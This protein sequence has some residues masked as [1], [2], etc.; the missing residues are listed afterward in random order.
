MNEVES[1]L[2]V[3]L[4][5]YAHMDWGALVQVVDAI[6]GITVTLDEDIADDWTNT[7]IRAGEPATLDGEAAL[8]LARARHGTTYGDF[9]RGAS[10]QKII[11]A[12]K[13]RI[14]EKG[15][16]VAETVSLLNALGDNLR[17]NFS[18]GEIK[19]SAK[20]LQDFPENGIRQVPLL[21][22]ASGDYMTT[23]DI[24]GIS[25]VVPSAGV[26][27]Y[28]Y[29]QKYVAKMFSSDPTVR[30]EAVIAVYNGSGVTGAASREQASLEE[31]GL[32]VGR[33]GDAPEG[34]YPQDY[35]LYD[36][37]GEKGA[38]RAI[39]EGKYNLQALSAEDLPEGMYVDGVD[40]I[41]I[42]G[43]TMN[44]GATGVVE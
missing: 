11:F 14:T 31:A 6:G 12:I 33:I 29:L 9:S 37:T 10:Q 38:T 39:L 30:E 36:L 8:G 28:S 44:A 27:V 40:F 20:M 22:T 17:T 3:S 13:D 24:G 19:S 23:A 4:Q 41:V 7:F 5:Y 16:S 42:V 18:V 15:L 21:E 35:Y 25:Y 34:E 26:G 32:T 43:G 1:I 2:G